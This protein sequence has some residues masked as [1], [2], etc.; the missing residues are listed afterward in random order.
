MAFMNVSLIEMS[1]AFDKLCACIKRQGSWQKLNFDTFYDMDLSQNEALVIAWLHVHKNITFSCRDISES[2]GIKEAEVEEALFSL[3]AHNFIKRTE[4]D[5][6]FDVV[7][8]DWIKFSILDKQACIAS[9]MMPKP[10][11]RGRP[12]KDNRPSLE[13]LENP[14]GEDDWKLEQAWEEEK[15]RREEEELNSHIIPGATFIPADRLVDDEALEKMENFDIDGDDEAF[16]EFE[17][18]EDY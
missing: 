9:G 6:I 18:E 15:R 4:S 17:E 12:K 13:E 11:K 5:D 2:L 8:L 7:D 1:D 14:D 10:I 16:P 3:I